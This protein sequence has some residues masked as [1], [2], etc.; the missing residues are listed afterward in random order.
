VIAKCR[1]VS[2][3]QDP[4]D[5]LYETLAEVVKPWVSLEILKRTDNELLISLLYRC[6]DLERQLGCRTRVWW[7]S[8]IPIRLLLAS[9]IVAA[10]L[11]WLGAAEGVFMALVDWLRSWA[12]VIW[13]TIKWSSDLERIFFLGIVLV[14]V[15]L[16]AV[17]RTARS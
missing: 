9:V 5:P 14:V 3:S 16:I 4:A 17:V 6:R 15:S 11:L 8:Q 12:V 10:L 13:V 2:E 7:R 1:S